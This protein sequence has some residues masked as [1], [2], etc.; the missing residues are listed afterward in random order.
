MHLLTDRGI[1]YCDSNLYRRYNT[2]GF[3]DGNVKHE[4][5]IFCAKDAREIFEQERIDDNVVIKRKRH[6]KEAIVASQT[7]VRHYGRIY[8]KGPKTDANAQALMEELVNLIN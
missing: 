5:P 7:A 4:V 3:P 6:S 2:E 8:D 1:C